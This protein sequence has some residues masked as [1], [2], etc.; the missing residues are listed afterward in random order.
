[1]HGT[2]QERGDDGREA[3]T[4]MD[5]PEEMTPDAPEPLEP[6][7]SPEPPDPPEPAA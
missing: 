5:D 6:P 7:P 4:A 3:D 2:Q 1:M